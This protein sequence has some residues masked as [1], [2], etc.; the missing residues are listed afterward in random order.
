M[1]MNEIPLRILCL[2]FDGVLHNYSRG[3]QGYDVID[4]EPVDG[5]IE[6]LTEA[7]EFFDVRIFSA[8]CCCN[9]GIFAMQRWLAKHV[10]KEVASKISF[11]Q[12]KP[13]AHLI[14]DDRAWSFK[15]MFPS[16][17]QVEN[18]R[19]WQQEAR[20]EGSIYEVLQ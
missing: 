10:S 1:H 6:F 5:A 15:G 12:V 11:A 13:H 20:D 4:G 14:I 18:Y 19:T 8:R 17:E 16:I 3:W 9:E 7:V 2:D